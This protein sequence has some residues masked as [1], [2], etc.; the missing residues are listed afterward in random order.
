MLKSLIIQNYAL[1]TELEIDFKK[2]FSVITGE[3]GAGKSIILGA[4]SLILGQRADSKS[5]KQGK[6]KCLVEGI[7][8]ISS[9]QLESFFIEKELYY[10][11]ENC[12]LRR[13]IW[14]T[15]KSR[16]FINDSPVSLS[17]LKE[18]SSY[19]I[20]IHSQ[21]ENLLLSNS[22]FQL[23][24]LDIV[25]RNK[26]IKEK[27]D[28]T[29]THFLQLKKKL[30]EV[31]EAA[32]KHSSEQDYLSFQYQ[33]LNEA[34]LISGEQNELEKEAQ[35]LS[36][37]EEIKTGL[38]SIEHFLSDENSGII[39]SLK[40]SLSTANALNK[41][42]SPAS[43]IAERLNTAYIDL[44]DLLYETGKTQEELEFNPERLN[45]I[46]ERLDLIYSLQQKHHVNSEEELIK[47]KE[48]IEYKLQAIDN[49][50]EEIDR[51]KAALNESEKEL[52]VE[53]QRLSD[54]RK[55][56]TEV[57]EKELTER[58]KILGMP[59][60]RFACNNKPNDFPGL[61]GLDNYQFLFSS[62][63]NGELKPI[64]QTASGGEISRIMLGIKSLIAGT[65]NLPTIIFDEIDSGVSGEI[66]DKMGMIMRQMGEVMQVITIT[67]LPQIAAK[68]D[69]QYFVFKNE[70]DQYAETQIRLLSQEERIREIAH[71]LSGS[72]L[73]EA[74]IANAKQLLKT[75]N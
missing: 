18:L 43:E 50:K 11:A 45:Y 61:N 7:F 67:H 4:L 62:N 19:L 53:A 8:D 2:G 73:T 48:E 26:Q 24:V 52:M 49:Y 68:G 42:Y 35:T 65:I 17:D 32:V 33:Q 34:K 31:E 15:G 22:L 30:T 28:Q 41:I 47:I 54:S 74:A 5:I 64:S 10:D 72:E 60:I 13:E 44:K 40:N 12:I 39:P 14:D 75:A 70:K 23:N 25:A 66:A 46:N 63:K 71:M 56:A 37:V 57:L 1:I 29:Y 16:A 21:H 69:S 3:T 59:N 27:Y 51:L 58:V 20:D 38:L 55:I 9:Y 36:H 6:N